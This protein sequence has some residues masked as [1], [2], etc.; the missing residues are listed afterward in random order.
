[1]KTLLY[2]IAALPLLATVALAQPPVPSNDRA[3][4]QLSENQMDKV[5]AGFGFLETDL[6]N[7]GL[8]IVSVYQPTGTG[9][10]PTPNSIGCPGC[11]LNI[12]NFALSIA[13]QMF[14]GL[15]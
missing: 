4:M 6:S 9:T 3:P 12:N 8:V 2:G 15:P 5:T 1:M 7:T 10:P 11:Y 14:G 13:S